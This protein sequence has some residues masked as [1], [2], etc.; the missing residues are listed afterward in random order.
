MIQA[1]NFMYHVFISYFLSLIICRSLHLSYFHN[2]MVKTL[3]YQLNSNLNAFIKPLTNCSLSP[4][5]F[6]S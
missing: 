5:Q 3:I 2:N 6:K 4:L 1:F